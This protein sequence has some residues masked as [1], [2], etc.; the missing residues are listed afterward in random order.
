MDIT[1]DPETNKFTLV[2]G[3]FVLTTGVDAVA[4]FVGQRL[5]TW[6]GEWFLDTTEGVP[7]REK[8]FL[9]NPNIVDVETTLKLI[10]IE[11]PG[12]IELTSFN[13][14]LDSA[15]RTAHLAFTANSQAGEVVFD[16]DIG[17]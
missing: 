17:A 16:Q 10:I 7:F 14:T 9:K 6:L 1:I 12:I 2:N 5:Q 13:L 15:A 3:D 4:Q 8:I 11:S